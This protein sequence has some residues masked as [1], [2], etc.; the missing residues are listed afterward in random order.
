MSKFKAKDPTATVVAVEGQS[1][2]VKDGVFEVP[3]ALDGPLLGTGYQVVAV[4]LAAV[5]PD[6]AKKQG[7]K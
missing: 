5:L 4:D 3:D 7:G 6:P 1:F 2:D